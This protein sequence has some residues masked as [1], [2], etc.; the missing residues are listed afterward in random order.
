LSTNE[1]GSKN[2]RGKESRMYGVKIKGLNLGK[3][4]KENVCGGE[5][6]EQPA[7]RARN[8]GGLSGEA[9]KGVTG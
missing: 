1:R 5:S 7:R 6:Q 2:A 8:A 4:K 3:K 9:L